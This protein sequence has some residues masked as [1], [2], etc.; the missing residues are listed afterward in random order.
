MCGGMSRRKVVGWVIAIFGLIVAAY[1]ISWEAF[2]PVGWDTVIGAALL[3][4]GFFMCKC[5]RWI[6]HP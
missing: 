1:G 4:T 2:S 3:V 6:T 5:G